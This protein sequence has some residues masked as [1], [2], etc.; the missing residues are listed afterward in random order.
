MKG[1]LCSISGSKYEKVVY[2]IL[3]NCYINNVKM[4]TQKEE[5]LGGSSSKNDIQCN[6]NGENDIGIEIK[7]S[8]TPDW[9]QCSIRYN[10]NTKKWE[11]SKK[12]R[13]PIKSRELF[14]KLINSVNLYNGEIPPFINKQITHD[15]WVKIKKETNKWNDVY[16]DIPSDC[17]SKLYREKN[18]Y[19]IQ[20]SD[21]YGLYHL[22]D[23]VCGFNVPLF[24][25]KQEIRIRTKIHKRKN[26][27]GYCN[28]SVMVSCKPKDIKNL[29]QSKYSLDSECMLPEII[30]YNN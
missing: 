19:Y 7:K 28:I 4:N 16:I 22:G 12:S 1:R 13:I 20:I 11:G 29:K 2:N 5:E 10:E 17:I 24:D 25:I 9:M 6:F 14:D 23:D 8:K 27:N 26:K 21:G 3:K 15:E 30:K 18:C